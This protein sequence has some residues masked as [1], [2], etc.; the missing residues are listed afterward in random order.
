MEDRNCV[1]RWMVEG[2]FALKKVYGM[3]E[4]REA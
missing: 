3:D 1:A 4:G 2:A